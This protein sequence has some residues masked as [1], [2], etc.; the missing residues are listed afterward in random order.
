MK[1]YVILFAKNLAGEIVEGMGSYSV[2][3]PEEHV[4]LNNRVQIGYMLLE[5]EN[6]L[7][8]N[9]YI[10]FRIYQKNQIAVEVIV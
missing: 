10:G 5:R 2:I 4:S 1:N 3:E 7:S 9:Y 8:N 6:K